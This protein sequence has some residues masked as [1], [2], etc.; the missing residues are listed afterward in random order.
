MFISDCMN[1]LE[2]PRVNKRE[3]DTRNI[4]NRA[5]LSLQGSLELHFLVMNKNLF[6][7]F[8]FPF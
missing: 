1:K 8:Y 5:L 4:T 6:I 2:L 3:A 7:V